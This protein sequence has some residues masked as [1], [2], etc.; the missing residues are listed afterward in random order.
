MNKREFL[1]NH[2]YKIYLLILQRD[3]QVALKYSKGSL[4]WSSLY[5]FLLHDNC[6]VRKQWAHRTTISIKQ[7]MSSFSKVK[8]THYEY[9]ILAEL[10]YVVQPW[11]HTIYNFLI[12][13][14]KDLYLNQ[15]IMVIQGSKL[16]IKDKLQKGIHTG[17]DINMPLRTYLLS[18][19]KFF[20]FSIIHKFSPHWRITGIRIQ[21][22]NIHQ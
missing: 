1:T 11:Q 21:I 6:M 12:F 20:I 22:R 2:K 3:Q 14:N 18:S 8:I 16:G 5:P 17:K 19:R 4:E 10:S 7:V 13:E 9:V 15:H